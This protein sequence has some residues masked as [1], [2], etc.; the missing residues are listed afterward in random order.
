MS[1]VC[2]MASLLALL[3]LAALVVS[4]VVKPAPV[5]RYRALNQS[6]IPR[7]F[8]GYPICADVPVDSAVREILSTGDIIEREY[9]DGPESI[10]FVLIGGEDRDSMHDPR[11]CLT[12]GGKKLVNDHIERLP[13]T[14][15]DAR[16]Y[17]AKSAPGDPNLDVMYFFLND[18]HVRNEYADIRR[19]ML[20][21]E[22]IGHKSGPIFFFRF[23][24]IVDPNKIE[25]KV[26]HRAM[27]RF[28]AQMW[29]AMGPKLKSLQGQPEV[30]PAS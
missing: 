21:N 5:P 8:P 2:R 9:G 24:R 22:L 12:G 20:W 29:L 23:I 30:D 4:A 15:V 27:A 26:E 13:G 7:S 16:V 19:S 1:Y 18:G 3:F 6:E 11:L 14:D 17:L 28:A 10:N 25:N